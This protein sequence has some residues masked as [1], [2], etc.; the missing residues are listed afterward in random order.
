[1]ESVEEI[2][3][4]KYVETIYDLYVGEQDGEKTLMEKAT[5]QQPLKFVFGIGQ[6]I[7]SFEKQLLH[8]NAGDK[9]DFVI[10]FADAYGEYNDE[11]VLELEKTMFMVDG[12]FDENMIFTGATVPMLDTN[13]NTLNGSVIELKDDMVVMDFNHP[14]AGEDLH[15]IGEILAVREA[16]PEELTPQSGCGGCSGCGDESDHQ[17]GGGCGDG[18]C[19]H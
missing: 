3:P 8:K 18:G 1:M 7:E 4:G 9:F 15:F 2:K 11:H 10:P 6:M 17:C 5:R 16:T 13:G 19:G 12:K 14:L